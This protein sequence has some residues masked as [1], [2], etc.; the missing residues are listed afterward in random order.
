MTT[1][2]KNSTLKSFNL[3]IRDTKT[4]DYLSEVL[5]SKKPE[6][7][8]NLISVVS[9]NEQLQKCEPMSLIFT[10]MKATALNLPIEPALGKAAIIPFN[11]TKAGVV[12][13]QF[14][15][16]RD[17]WVELLQ[18]SGQVQFI[19]NEPV[20]EGEL[21][22]KNKFTGEYVFDENRRTSDKI[23]GYMAYVRLKNGFEKTVYWTVEEINAHAKRYSQTFKKGYGL[24]VD[25]YDSMALKGLA[26]DT[27]IPTPTGFTT[28]GEVKVGDIVYN[29]LG[30]ETKVIAKSEVKH[31]PCYEVVFQNGDSFV[32]D[33]EHRWF[34]KGRNSASNRGEWQVLETK[35]LYSVKSLGYTVITPATPTVEMEAKELL[36]DPYILGYWLGNGSHKAA[37]VSC[38]ADDSDEITAQFEKFYCVSVR[39]DERSNAVVLNI[40]SKT[41]L[42]SD[43]SSL[44]QQLQKIGV[45]GNK[46]IPTEYKRASFAQRLSLLQGLCDSDGSIDTQRGRCS[47]TSVNQQLAEDIYELVSSLG[48]RANLNSGTVRGYGV[49]ATVYTV[50]WTPRFNPFR[51]KRKSDRFREREV[52]VN[53][54]IKCIREVES[55]P[56]QC[57]AVDSGDATEENDLRKSYLIGLGFYPTHNTVL[58]HL[59][60]KYSP[61]SIEVVNRAI[62]MDY[63]TYDGENAEAQYLD[64][65]EAEYDEVKEPTVEEKKE[66]MR[67]SAKENPE[68]P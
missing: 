24:W 67:K 28:M 42:R 23:I 12:K 38:W 26:L 30:E 15:V 51:L 7:V 62:E 34:C 54:S 66:Q 45:F 4:Q 35:D 52:E 16:M 59:I 37:N 47:Y 5:G 65:P 68:L 44:K 64:N 13:A 32:C 40:S 6:F 27:L 10:A 57:I 49:T 19:A 31:L 53:N 1:T 60:K 48:E 20:H 36:V 33:S 17:G 41:G 46:H 58:K 63:A 18:R 8:A 55:V 56:T 25:N 39:E 22:K 43:V 61:V 14:Q 2:L 21:V 50:M 11:D 29:A 3:A 9:G